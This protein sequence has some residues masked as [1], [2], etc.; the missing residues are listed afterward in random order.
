MGKIRSR[1]C[2]HNETKRRSSRKTISLSKL[3]LWSRAKKFLT[4]KRSGQRV[5]PHK[6]FKRS[7]REDYKRDLEVPGIIQ[8][9]EVIFTTTCDCSAVERDSGWYY[10]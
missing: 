7:Y 10:E 5:N 2:N 4:S 9:L 3:N 1:K 8:K 6:S